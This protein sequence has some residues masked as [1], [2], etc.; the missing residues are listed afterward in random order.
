MRKGHEK[1]EAR[2][3]NIIPKIS[4]DTRMCV[5]KDNN[6][7]SDEPYRDMCHHSLCVHRIYQTE[8]KTRTATKE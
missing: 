7:A 5:D 1:I 6:T 2:L 4:R 8:P 3:I